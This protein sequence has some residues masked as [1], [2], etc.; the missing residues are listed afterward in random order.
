M[1]DDVW[2]HDAESH[3]AESHDAGV[4]LQQWPGKKWGS[5]RLFSGNVMKCPQELRLATLHAS[6]VKA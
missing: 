4:E 1:T 6:Q 2:C 3:D 5:Q